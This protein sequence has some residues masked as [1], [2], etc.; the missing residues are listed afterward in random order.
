MELAIK[1]FRRI[2]RD[3]NHHI[4]L[5]K[6]GAKYATK[7]DRLINSNFWAIHVPRLLNDDPLL[8]AIRG[9]AHPEVI[10]VIKRKLDYSSTFLLNDIFYKKYTDDMYVTLSAYENLPQDEKDDIIEFSKIDPYYYTDVIGCYGMVYKMSIPA[11][12]ADFSEYMEI[13]LKY[14]NIYPGPPERYREIVA[15]YIKIFE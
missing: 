6:D 12:L 11:M 13:A 14:T 7:M 3:S 2:I 1:V 9:L 4:F 15:E 10:R 8:Y 5:D